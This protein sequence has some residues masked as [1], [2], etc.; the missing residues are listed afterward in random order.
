MLDT[1][2]RG[3]SRDGAAP[4]GFVVEGVIEG[5]LAWLI[6]PV[7]LENYTFTFEL[8]RA[9]VFERQQQAV[10]AGSSVQCGYFDGREGSIAICP[11]TDNYRANVAA[12]VPASSAPISN[13]LIEQTTSDGAEEQKMADRYRLDI[14]ESAIY[15]GERRVLKLDTGGGVGNFSN[16]NWRA[17]IDL[18]ARIVT[19][20]NEADG[21]S[22]PSAEARHQR[23]NTEN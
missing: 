14:D 22:A 13:P 2:A 16:D 10:D 21:V 8:S 3:I 20:L 9:H 17:A 5:R 18:G 11:L 15:D 1:G 7:P 4:R 19:L 6:E 23:N 12:G